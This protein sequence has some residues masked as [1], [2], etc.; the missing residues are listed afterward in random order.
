VLP[1][2]EEA[3]RIKPKCIWLQLG[4][5]NENAKNIAKANDIFFIQNRCIK[6]EHQN[7]KRFKPKQSEKF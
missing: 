5:T 3:V 1:I 7:L 6:I 4:I 2:V